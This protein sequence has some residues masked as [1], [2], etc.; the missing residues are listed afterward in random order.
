MEIDPVTNGNADAMMTETAATITPATPVPSSRLSQLTESLKLEHQLLRVPFEHYKKTI[1]S[2]HRFFE[3]EV[4]SVVSGVGDLADSDWSKD[5][6]V[7]RL[8][9]LVSRLQG[10]KRKVEFF[11]CL[12]LIDR[13]RKL[14]NRN[15]ICLVW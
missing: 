10:L 8:T 13:R 11:F 3:K 12:S 5:D 2:N 15:C 7:S 14:R 9:S 1:R 4:S 6:T